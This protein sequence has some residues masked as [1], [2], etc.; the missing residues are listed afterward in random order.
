M[1]FRP[2]L[3]APRVSCQRSDRRVTGELST[4]PSP[5]RPPIDRFR[6][7]RGEPSGLSVGSL[8]C[9][10]GFPPCPTTNRAMGLAKGEAMCGPPKTALRGASRS[11]TGPRSPVSRSPA[12]LPVTA[13]PRVGLI[14]KSSTFRRRRFVCGRATPAPSLRPA[15]GRQRAPLSRLTPSSSAGDP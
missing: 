10:H 15:R 3:C 9:T 1:P 2:W 13:G 14:I 12:V 4:E 5:Q 6:I 11:E 8:R 7:A